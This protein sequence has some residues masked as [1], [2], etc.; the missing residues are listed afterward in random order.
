MMAVALV[1]FMAHV[2]FA[3]YNH[4]GTQIQW[5]FARFIRTKSVQNLTVVPFVTAVGPIPQV[6]RQKRRLS[7]VVS[8]VIINTAT[9]QAGMRL[10][11]M[12]G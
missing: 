7:V 9:T 5:T 11:R 10:M 2:G 8:G 1:L 6:R 3:A 4:V 12:T